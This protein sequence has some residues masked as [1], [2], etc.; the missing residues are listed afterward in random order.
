MSPLVSTSPML[1]PLPTAGGLTLAR[2][3]V[4]G[5]LARGQEV[6]RSTL[7]A[8]LSIA[9]LVEDHLVAVLCVLVSE[10]TVESVWRDGALYLRRCTLAS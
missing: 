10:G 7:A 2:A 4:E 3:L 5:Q 8:R 9:G 1:P 6:S